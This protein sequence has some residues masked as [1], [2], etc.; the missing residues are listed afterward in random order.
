M[1]LNGNQPDRVQFWAQHIIDYPDYL[2]PEALFLHLE[3]D[4]FW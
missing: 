4:D 2:T 1:G 3:H